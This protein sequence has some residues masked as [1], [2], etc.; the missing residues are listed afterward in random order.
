MYEPN[1]PLWYGSKEQFRAPPS[2]KFPIAR[3]SQAPY[4]STNERQP[5]NN[6]VIKIREL[7]TL[8]H[9]HRAHFNRDPE[10]ILRSI[11]AY[12]SSREDDSIIDEKLEQL[13]AL[14][15]KFCL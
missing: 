11:I 9:R 1:N 2:Y 12:S 15:K 4:K 6:R 5:P 13:R 3:P 14:D 8:L 7:E 10:T